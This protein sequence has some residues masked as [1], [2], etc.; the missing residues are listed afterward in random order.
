MGGSRSARALYQNAPFPGIFA[1]HK[2]GLELSS[3]HDCK[4]KI[5]TSP[6]LRH[7]P[8]RPRTARTTSR[9]SLCCTRRSQRRRMALNSWR[10]GCTRSRKLTSPRGTP[11]RN[12]SRKR[13]RAKL[14][15]KR[16]PMMKAQPAISIQKKTGK[17]LMIAQARVLNGNSGSRTQKKTLLAA[18]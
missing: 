15:R 13:R 4:E 14:P 12:P 16:I 17:A 10:V 9:A 8:R 2:K 11:R 6:A 5:L 3:Y 18:G 1:N 7:M